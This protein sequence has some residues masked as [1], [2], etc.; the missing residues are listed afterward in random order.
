M[1]SIESTLSLFGLNFAFF[2]YQTHMHKNNTRT[3]THKHIL[4]LKVC[5][6]N[7]RNVTNFLTNRWAYQDERP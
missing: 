3:H 5:T 6:L 1:K 4:E 7:I 2:D